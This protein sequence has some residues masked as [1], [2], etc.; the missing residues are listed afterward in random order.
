MTVLQMPRDRCVV[1]GKAIPKGRGICDE[2]QAEQD[3]TVELDIVPLTVETAIRFG[4]GRV[5]LL[6]AIRYLERTHYDLDAIE[7]MEELIFEQSN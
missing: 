2:C 3:V 5:K 6:H 7:V 1:C 4:D